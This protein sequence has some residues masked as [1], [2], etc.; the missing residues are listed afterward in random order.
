MPTDHPLYGFCPACGDAIE[1]ANITYIGN[2]PVCRRCYTES[3]D[4]TERDPSL[5]AVEQA[6]GAEAA[7]DRPLREYLH[8]PFPDIDKLI[9]GIPPGDVG[10]LAG[11]MGGGKTLFVTSAIERWLK[12]GKKVYCL[13]LESEPLTFRTNLACKSLGLHAGKVLTGEY[14]RSLEWDAWKAMRESI[15]AEL[16][17]QYADGMG[18]RLFVSPTARMDTNAL[19][20]AARHAAKL[21]ADVFIIDHI[22]HVTAQGKSGHAESVSV[23]DTTLDVTREYGLHTIATSQL[24]FDG[25][26]GGDKLAK[27]Q[28][29]QMQHLYMGGKKG[30]IAAWVGGLNRPLQFS[31]LD[32]DTMTQARNGTIEAWKVLQPNCMG[33]GVMKSRHFGEHEGKRTYL[34]VENG[35]VTDLDEA[36]LAQI[37]HGIHLHTAGAV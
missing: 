27:Y 20:K 9:G 4:V 37:E 35:C 23:V 32:K 6:S 12:N 1:G 2:E 22:D 29:P 7:V 18:S 30:Q 19:K 28:F 3:P 15:V 11:F 10:F 31:G 34:G 13:P 25:I 14:K 24:N 33:F 17:R 21:G 16:R 8:I 36:L 5:T 26:R